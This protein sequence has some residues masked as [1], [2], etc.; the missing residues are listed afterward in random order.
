MMLDGAS[1]EMSQHHA[2]NDCRHGA[3]GGI[4]RTGSSIASVMPPA[5]LFR[6]IYFLSGPFADRAFGRMLFI[7]PSLDRLRG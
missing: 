2:S 1:G 7:D 5:E 3:R 4:A 6:V